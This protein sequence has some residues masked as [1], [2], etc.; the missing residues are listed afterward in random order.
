MRAAARKA[1][2]GADGV[3]VA[4]QSRLALGRDL[5]TF[6]FWGPWARVAPGGVEASQGGTGVELVLKGTRRK[7]MKERGA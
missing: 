3:A 7:V 1:R 2:L 4:A 6:V 5:A